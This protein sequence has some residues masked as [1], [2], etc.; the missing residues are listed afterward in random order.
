MLQRLKDHFVRQRVL[1]V[2]MGGIVALHMWWKF[3]QDYG[4]GD[5]NQDYPHKRMI[6]VLSGWAKTKLYGPD[7]DEVRK[8][9]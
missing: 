5:R 6:P 3:I 9:T 2:G 7:K 8:E 1:Y 4:P